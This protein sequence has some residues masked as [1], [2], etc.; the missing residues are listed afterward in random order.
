M[1]VDQENDPF[2]ANLFVLEDGQWRN[3]RAK[4]TPTFTSRKIKI[5]FETIANCAIGLTD[6]MESAVENT[7]P[8]DKKYILARLTTDII[9]STAFGLECNSLKNP[10]TPFRIYCKRNLEN[11]A[12]ERFKRLLSIILPKQFLKIIKFK[13]A[14]PDVEKFFSKVVEDNVEY[15]EKNNIH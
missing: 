2:I 12:L 5:M 8:I 1:F 10:N 11:T 14:K 13:L 4:L 15:R 7:K 9:A 6:I 3:L